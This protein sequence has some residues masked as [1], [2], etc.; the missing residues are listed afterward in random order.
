MSISSTPHSETNDSFSIQDDGVYIAYA[1]RTPIGKIFGA[2]GAVRPDDL[3]AM[4]LKDFR[5]EADT[6]NFSL[7]DLGDVIIGAANQAGEDNRNV[8]RMSLLLAGYPYSVPGVTI[9]RL[10]A[11]SLEALGI[12]HAKIL[13]GMMD[14]ALVGGVESMTRAPYVL[15]KSDKAFG[16]SQTLFDTT[17]GWRFPNPLLEQRFPLEGMGETAENVARLLN[18]SREEQDQFALSSH[19]KYFKAHKENAFHNEMLPI[20]QLKSDECPRP[21]TNIDQLKTLKPAFKK[22]GSVTAG[23]SSPMND[24]ASLVFVIKGS[25]LKKTKFTPLLQILGQRAKGVDPSVMGLGPVEAT[26][27]LLK[28]FKLSIDDI[29]YFEINEA[30]SAQVLG[31]VKELSIP[32]HKVNVHGGAIA[33]GHPLGASGTR[34][35]TTLTHALEH[36]KS[37]QTLNHKNPN[38]VLS[39]ATMC[40]GVGMGVSMLFTKPI[41]P[42][43]P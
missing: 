22:D 40:V 10:C 13:S 33:L 1:K 41:P 20:T 6:R 17:F 8:A 2:L 30:F 29:D 36:M 26:R 15:S 21:D 16:R 35:V 19:Q 14:C 7:E 38:Q 39:V 25:L 31:C 34:I 24:G 37:T 18:I 42:N 12:A 28:A 3:L 11:S 27:E 5:D 23:N 43:C 32:L 4:L 9:N